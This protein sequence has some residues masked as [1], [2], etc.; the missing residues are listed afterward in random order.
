MLVRQNVSMLMKVQI[1]LLVGRL[2]MQVATLRI[3]C[4]H[5]Y[6]KALCIF[7]IVAK[8]PSLSTVVS[9]GDKEAPQSKTEEFPNQR[10]KKGESIKA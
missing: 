9:H 7:H 8:P 3:R 1:Q 10:W 2:Q 5:I 4:L 6:C